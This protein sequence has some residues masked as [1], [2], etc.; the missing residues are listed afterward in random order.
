MRE[1][2]RR[3]QEGL[4]HTLLMTRLTEAAIPM[5]ASCTGVQQM[6]DID[7]GKGGGGKG[8]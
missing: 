1:S 8:N 2:N 6:W 4:N 5:P 3:A 7:R